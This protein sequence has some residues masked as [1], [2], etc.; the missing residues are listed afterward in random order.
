MKFV[1]IC[2]II[3][4]I[5]VIALCFA[6]PTVFARAGTDGLIIL[7]RA[8][9]PILFPFFF[10]SSFIV[11][12]C[13]N[14]SKNSVITAVLLSYFSGYPN[15]ARLVGQ[16]YTRGEISKAKAQQ[17]C[18]Y[19]A[20]ASPIFVIV[21]VGTI[22]LGNTTFGILIFIAMVTGAVLNGYIWQNKIKSKTVKCAERHNT[23]ELSILKAFN[24]AIYS[25]I[26]SILNVCGVILIFYI[27]VSVINTPP[28]LSGIIEMTTGAAQVSVLHLPPEFISTIICFFVSFGGISVAMQSFIF[29]RDFDMSPLYYFSYKI[30]HAVISAGVLSLIFF[31]I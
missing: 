21:S 28:L 23:A 9:L 6:N 10:I 24:S 29:M 4:C 13:Q 3:L 22:M 30:T 16:L 7:Y 5:V 8:V 12:L 17:L 15:G 27:L 18:V 25:A 26:T 19:T 31:V 14:N 1:H 11:N 2:V 20:T